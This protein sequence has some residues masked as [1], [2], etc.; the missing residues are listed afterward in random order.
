MDL[1]AFFTKQNLGLT[2]GNITKQKGPPDSWQA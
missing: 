2:S 1:P